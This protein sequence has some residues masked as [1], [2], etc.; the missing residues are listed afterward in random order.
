MSSV[1]QPLLAASMVVVGAQY[2]PRPDAKQYSASL[3]AKCLGML[4]DRGSVTSRSPISDLQTVVHL[5]MFTRYRARSAKVEHIQGSPLFQS[6]FASLIADQDW[7][8]TG[9][10]GLQQTLSAVIAPAQLQAVYGRWLDL[11]TRRRILVAAFVLD[12]QHRHL[13]QQKPSDPDIFAGEDDITVPFPSSSEAWDCTDLSTW[14]DTIAS[15]HIF[16][17]DT[18]DPSLP[19]LDRFQSSLRTCYQ[20]YTLERVNDPTESDLTFHPT[21]CDSLA[22]YLTYHALSFSR[23]TPLHALIVTASESWLF[24]SKITDKEIW[25]QNRHTV[26]SWVSSDAAMK[27]V[28]HATRLL[29]LSFQNQVQQVHL[30]D[31]VSYMHDL[32]CLYTAA[33]VCWAFGYGTAGM[34]DV[35]VEWQAEHAESLAWEY[36]G[37]MDVQG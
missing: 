3:H 7:L 28:W 33:L 11:E 26:R 23:H 14:R 2:S 19:P 6:L 17:L 30:V 16:Y 37:A 29:R 20:I 8:Q 18:L 36:L 15:Q 5:E 31:G 21:K 22:T 13:L 9:H 10:I 27:A 4:S 24:G 1:P 34:V 25:Q 32:W 35:Q 12:L